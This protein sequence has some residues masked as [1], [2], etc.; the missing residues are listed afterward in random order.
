MPVQSAGAPVTRAKSPESPES[1]I[2]VNVTDSEP[3]LVIVEVCAAVGP[4]SMSRDP[5][6]S[7]GLLA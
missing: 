6:A 2:D 5:N 1:A 4:S 7:V 3:L